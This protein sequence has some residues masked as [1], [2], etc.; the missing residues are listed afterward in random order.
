MS[1]AKEQTAVKHDHGSFSSL[2][3][4]LD[5]RHFR[6]DAYQDEEDVSSTWPSLSLPKFHT[7]NVDNEEPLPYPGEPV[8]DVSEGQTIDIPAKSDHDSRRPF[9]VS[10]SGDDYCGS[11]SESQYALTECSQSRRCSTVTYPSLDLES[12]RKT[13]SDSCSFVDRV[14]T[15]SLQSEQNAGSSASHYY[16]LLNKAIEELIVKEEK[17]L[18]NK[19]VALDPDLY[20][21]Y[22]LLE[23]TVRGR[24]REQDTLSEAFSFTN[25][26][27]CSNFINAQEN[28]AMDWESCLEVE[29]K[30]ADLQSLFASVAMSDLH[31]DEAFEQLLKLYISVLNEF[32]FEPDSATMESKLVKR[33]E[34]K[35]RWKYTRHMY[36]QA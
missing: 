30:I 23:D 32:S 6:H 15:P 33:F 34:E 5:S 12:S 24:E 8:G 7:H 21:Y 16:E 22:E 35:A 3:T 11:D 4:L 27:V 9:I 14:E 29:A 13:S 17:E 31:E 20:Y 19:H 10:Q 36:T 28:H 2:R 18:E 25:Y 26:K 1:E